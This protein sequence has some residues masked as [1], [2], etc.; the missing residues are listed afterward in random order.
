M[1]ELK[2]GFFW[3]NS[4]SSMQTEGA[5]NEDGKG[6]S[7]YDIKKAGPNQS[8]WKVAIDE[9]HRYSEDISLMQDLGMNFYR[10][11]ISWSR[12]QPDGEGDFNQAGIDFYD[13]L[14]DELLA[15]GVQ[16]MVCLYHFDMP[17]ALAEKYNGFVSKKVVE[18]Y[19]RF[20]KKMVDHFGD[21]VKYWLSFNEQN[22][23]SLK[24]AFT[25]S[26][27]LHGEETLRELY[28]IQHNTMLAHARLANY[29]H[30][31]KPDL[32]IGGMLAFQEVYPASSLPADVE[33]AR[34]FMTFGDFNLLNVF[35]KGQYLP[36][37]TSFMVQKH[38]DDILE[39]SELAE[40]AQTRS[41]FISFS[42]YTSTT[43]SAAKIPIATVPN[44]YGDFGA[45]LNPALR[46]NEWGWQIDPEGF[47][48]ILM[49]LYNRTSLPIFPIEN[50]IGMREVWDGEHQID[51]D[52]RI[53]Y[54]RL[55]IQALKRAV[56]DGA[57][58]IGYLGWGLIDIPSSKGDVEKR[59]GLV[60][61]NRS[62]HDL[63]DLKRVPK[64]SYAWF[65]R[66]TRSNGEDL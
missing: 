54:H 63:R 34:K 55:H 9:Y 66:V 25:S 28:Q 4:T 3:G 61:V 21:R 26:G 42:Y 49:D 15:K 56:K 64:K 37:V 10:F 60:Y 44:F 51:D 43:I 33:A 2:Q 46:T 6:R 23:F 41:D 30:L 18:A 1:G 29:I 5:W 40:I 7:V 38:L 62:N 65:R 59:Y 58:V 53:D 32:K 14:I 48:G 17:L 36:E 52:Y 45:E 24:F 39:P 47:Y 35:V 50:G 20:A 16:P 22:C 12:V 31:Q 13:R 19:T 57:D 11:Q 27:Y 8:D